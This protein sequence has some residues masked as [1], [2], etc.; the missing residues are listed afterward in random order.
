MALNLDTIR[1][2]AERVAASHHLDVVD[3]E[4]QGAGKA[5]ALRVFIE[6]NAEERAGLATK[7]TA[8]GAEEDVTLPK[9]VPV[10]T[11]SGVTHEDC[12][13]FAQDFGTVLDVE[14]LIPGAEYTLE[15]S[16]P[17]LERKLY[18]PE[19][20]TRFTGCLVKVQT[21]AAINNNR[22]W[23]GRLTKF[24]GNVVTLDLTA[25]KQKGKAKKAV[26]AAEI[27]IPLANV[28]KAQLVA[29]F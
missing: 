13:A 6:K 17:G 18:R 11:L 12:S 10:E 8:E 1:A 27:E 20:Y 26:T 3:L 25:I 15:V 9:G 4:F 29:E 21:F 23:Q 19:D 28:E 7:A 22:H 14:N 2:T 16:S 24:E 5:R